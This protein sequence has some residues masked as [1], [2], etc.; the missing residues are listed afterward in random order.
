[1]IKHKLSFALFG[2]ALLMAGPVFAQ[3]SSPAPAGQ[4]AKPAAVSPQAPAASGSHRVKC[5]EGTYIE[6]PQGHVVCD[7]PATGRPTMVTPQGKH[8]K[9]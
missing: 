2:A 7:D 9:M 3:S 6:Q 8:D 1:M 4:A 5:G